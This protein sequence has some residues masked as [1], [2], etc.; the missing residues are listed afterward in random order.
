LQALSKDMKLLAIVFV[1]LATAALLAT[2][3]PISLLDKH[4]P[5]ERDG[6]A[7]DK[8]YPKKKAVELMVK[9]SMLETNQ[10]PS[11]SRYFRMHEW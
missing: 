1:F 3:R 2:A 6:V 9:Q 11:L 8:H 4:F 10:L 5:D 7:I